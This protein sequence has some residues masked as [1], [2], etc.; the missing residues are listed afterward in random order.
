MKRTAFFILF[1]CCW[2]SIFS[3]TPDTG[4]LLRQLSDSL[5]YCIKHRQEYINKKETRIRTI[6]HR[7]TN[8]PQDD[9]QRYE[10]YDQ[11]SKEYQ[12]FNVDSAIHYAEKKLELSTLHHKSTE[13]TRSKIDL[14]LLCSMRGRYL[15]AEKILQSINSCSLDKNLR[16][17]YY[18]A[19]HQFWEYY[20]ISSRD[21]A[22]AK[23][24]FALYDDSLIHVMDHSS[25]SYKIL[26]ANIA[27]N[28]KQYLEAEKKFKELLADE[29]IG[30][31]HY[32]MITCGLAFNYMTLNQPDQAQI[33]FTL[34][35]IT[36]LRNATREN[37]SLQI[38]A[39]MEFQNKN[40]E[41]ASTYA[42]IAVEDAVASGIHFRTSQ[43]YQFYTDLN[44]Q[45]KQEETK[46]KA[47]LRTSLIVISCI[48][49]CLI[50]LAI[51]IV[52]QIRRISRIKETLSQSNE[53]L[54]E[55]NN[56]LNLMNEE[57]NHK[58]EE[59]H[60]IG[61]I[62][63]KYI[64]QFFDLCSS[65]I[66]K[67]ENYQNQ[68]YK[69]AINHHYEMLVKRLKSTSQIDEE[70]EALYKHFDSIFLSLYPTFIEEFNALLSEN[71][72]ITLKSE[73]LLNK[74]L[75]IYALLRL[76]LVDSNKM[77]SFLRCSIST[78]YNYRTKMRNKSRIER[79]DFEN[80][81]MQI[82]KADTH[83]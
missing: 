29:E 4:T 44:A 46:Q 68:L 37:M 70:L 31:A 6:K 5:N 43:I 63:E 27:G 32:A 16:A 45:Y 35:A 40:L 75:R 57:L 22:Y 65:Y 55:L 9:W 79:D 56:R 12:K 59:L 10:I 80:Q 11:L 81:V 8:K 36:D 2:V 30:S 3:Q 28:K 64:A 61:N 13:L 60:E 73:H 24:Q 58:N 67:M 51:Y 19:Y 14:S 7:L 21:N 33:Y 49:F 71:E 76:G 78:I 52:L 53:Q 23:K 42:Q 15:E 83:K 26:Q 62:K 25:I 47:K 38:L 77:A 66:S 48:S 18:S 41:L 50:L 34:S 74:E 17:E 39:M 1:A 72:K 69:L 20:S 54:R 82:G